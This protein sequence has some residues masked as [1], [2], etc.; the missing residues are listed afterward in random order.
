MIL[1]EVFKTHNS[2]CVCLLI[3]EDIASKYCAFVFACSKSTRS[4]LINPTAKK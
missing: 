4:S 1:T 2:L 3:P